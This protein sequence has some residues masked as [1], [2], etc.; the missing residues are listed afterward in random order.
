VSYK[1]KTT[2]RKRY[3]VR[4]N[5]GVVNPRE[6]VEVQS[7]HYYAFDSDQLVLLNY[8]KDQPIDPKTKDKFQV[9]SIFL[10]PEQLTQDLKAVVN[11]ISEIS[12]NFLSGRQ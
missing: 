4:P 5:T 7:T 1:I 10:E 2:A 9:Q 3:C 8:S 6:T 11:H 12:S